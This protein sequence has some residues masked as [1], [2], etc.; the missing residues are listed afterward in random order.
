VIENL[1][2][3]RPSLASVICD[4]TSLLRV[5]LTRVKAKRF[6]EVKVHTRPFLTPSL[7]PS[8]LLPLIS[9]AGIPLLSL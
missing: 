7:P 9:A 8:L 5:L 6:D 2:T 3:V 1:V 4:K